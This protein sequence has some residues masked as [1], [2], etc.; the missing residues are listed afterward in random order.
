[1]ILTDTNHET[2]GVIYILHD[3]TLVPPNPRAVVS[4]AMLPGDSPLKAA[5]GG[6][7]SSNVGRSRS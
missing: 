4:P 6:P 7:S 2:P 3:K 1:M 5:V